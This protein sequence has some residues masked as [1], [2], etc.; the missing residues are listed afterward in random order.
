MNILFVFTLGSE[1]RQFIHSGVISSIIDNKHNV[2]ISAKNVPELRNEIIRCEPRAIMADFYEVM[3]KRSFLTYYQELLNQ[4]FDKSQKTW[5][6]VEEK[7]RKKRVLVEHSVLIFNRLGAYGILKWVESFLFKVRKRDSWCKLLIK[8]KI[9]RIAVNVPGSAL[10]PLM[11]AFKLKVERVLLYHT[12]K[13]VEA[14]SR[15]IVPFN[16]IGLW[17][18]EMKEAFLIKYRRPANTHLEVIG[19]SHF[20]YLGNQ[21]ILLNEM[22]F[23]T[24]FNLKTSQR[25]ILYTAA[26]PWVIKNEQAFVALIR[27]AIREL[28][29]GDYKIIIRKNPMDYTDNWDTLKCEDLE[30]NN[31]K[32]FWDKAQN[33][34]FTLKE[35]LEEYFSLLYYSDLCVNIPSSVTIEAA[36]MQL[37]VIN[38]CFDQPGVDVINNGKVVDFWN[39]SFNK[40]VKNNRI[41]YP[42]FSYTEL[43]NCMRIILNKNEIDSLEYARKQFLGQILHYP[44][45]ELKDRSVSF[46]LN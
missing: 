1:V 7:E 15:I 29:V 16:K 46:I 31:P 39:A 38:L 20:C 3:P 23:R 42:A 45:D 25:I 33:I 27:Q 44:V 5:R 26:A 41:V 21:D 11:A 18:E 17:N 40:A 8:Y 10:L 4:V 37:P 28:Q 30:I 36:I 6:Y 2:F 22:E 35:D 19:N 14:Q 43:V 9:D 32:W 12:N 34:N 24:R 13:D